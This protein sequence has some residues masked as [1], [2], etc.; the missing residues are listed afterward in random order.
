MDNLTI[1]ELIELAK[2]AQHKRKKNAEACLK[3][4]H[5]HHEEM[6]EKRRISAKKYYYA[7]KDKELKAKELELSKNSI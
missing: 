3:Y 5:A 4:Y 6:K 7:K 1:A 2:V